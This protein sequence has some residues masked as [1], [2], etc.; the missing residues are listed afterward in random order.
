MKNLTLNKMKSGMSLGD[1][2]VAI[3]EGNIGLITMLP[4]ICHEAEE[5]LQNGRGAYGILSMLDVMRIYGSDLAILLSDRCKYDHANL[6]TIIWC[7]EVGL[8]QQQLK[9]NVPK[10]AELDEIKQFI[11]SNDATFPFK[12][13]RI[14]IQKNSSIRFS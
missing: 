3:A 14:F 11:S 2:I 5:I 1:C 13:A 7:F 12:E 6:L 8:M 9:R 10:F 4:E